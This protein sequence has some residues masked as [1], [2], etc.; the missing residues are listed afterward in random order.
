MTFPDLADTFSISRDP[1]PNKDKYCH[2]HVDSFVTTTSV[3]V[4]AFYEI[5]SSSN[6][7]VLY[8]GVGS[9]SLLNA[10]IVDIF[11]DALDNLPMFTVVEVNGKYCRVEQVGGDRIVSHLKGMWLSREMIRRGCASGPLERLS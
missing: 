10:N 11:M 9:W 2:M 5:P 8:D 4:F 7:D 6:A 3:R 1:G